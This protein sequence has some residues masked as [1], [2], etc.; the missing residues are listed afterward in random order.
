MKQIYGKKMS[1]AEMT[2]TQKQLAESS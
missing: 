1:I 2:I